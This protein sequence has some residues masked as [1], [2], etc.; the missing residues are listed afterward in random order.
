MMGILVW[1]IAMNIFY[2]PIALG[3]SIIFDFDPLILRFLLGYY[4]IYMI[5]MFVM[6]ITIEGS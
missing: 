5:I 3:F 2:I 1:F 4:F 6:E